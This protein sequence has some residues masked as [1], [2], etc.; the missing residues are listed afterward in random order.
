MD[1]SRPLGCFAMEWA[2][3]LEQHGHQVEKPPG[4]PGM[5]LSR[6]GQ[7]KRYR[8]L[9]LRVEGDSVLLT[10]VDR[11]R[12]CRQL[13]LAQISGETAY[14]VVKFEEPGE[15]VVVVPA[16]EAVRTKRLNSDK[17]GIP[18]HR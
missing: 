3:Y 7:G 8:W 14:M 2:S 6:N 4:A 16:I 12:I 1:Q 15:K 18:W 17:G 11:K 13:R 10:V 9:L 5:L